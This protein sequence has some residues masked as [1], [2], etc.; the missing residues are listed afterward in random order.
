MPIKSTQ[1]KFTSGEIDPLLLGRSDLDR[2]YGAAE[3]IT[4]ARILPQGGIKRDDGLEYI[5]R[6]HR[7]V[8]RETSPTITTPNGGTGANANDDDTTTELITT[9]NISTTNPYVVVHY[10][11]GSQKDLAFI[12]VVGA[13]LT[14]ATNS[15][16]FFI[17]VSTD[18]ATWASLGDAIDMSSSDV[19]RRRR[20]RG[21]YRYVR[22]AR[23]GS[24]DLT[25][26]KVTLDEFSVWV[27]SST[28]SS[29]KQI[30]FEFS[31]TQ[32]Y[33]LVLTD[34]NIAV[35]RNKEHQI[36]VRAT[37]ITESI[38]SN[39][40]HT[41]SADTAILVEETI[42][43]QKLT[44]DGSD[45]KWIIGDVTFE[46]VPKYDFDPVVSTSPGGGTLTPSATSGIITLT[47][48]AG[49]PFS[50][51]SVGQYLT[52]G[53]GRAR[54]I[55]YTST[56]VVQA[57]TEIPF[58]NTTA[59]AN[60]SWDYLTGWEDAWSS[61]RGYPKTVTFH[62]GRLFFGGST[63]RPQTVWGSKVGVFFDFDLGSLDDS[64]GLDATLNTDQINE[65]VNLK[66]TNGNLLVF[67]SGAEFVIPQSSS[68]TITPA[69]FSFVPV[70][71][72]GSEPGFNIGVI[73]GSNIFIQRGG[74]S[75]LRFAY[76]TL[77]Q[78]SDSENLSLLSSHLI[79]SPLDFT[80]RKST[81][82]EETNLILFINGSG[83]LV[84][85]TVL[86]TQGVIGF[87]KRET[88]EASGSFVNVAVD[89][90][91]IYTVV[92]RTVN[93]VTNKYIEVM[94]DD[95]LL[96][97]S[98]IITTGLPT[99]TFSGLDHLEGETVKVIADGSIL[100][101]RVVSSG[102]ITIERDA[103][104]SIEIGL[105]MSPIIKTLPIEVA[106]LGSR[107]GV[108]KRI[109]EVVLRLYN[110]GDFTVNNDKVSFRTFGE[111]GAGSPLDAAPPTFTGDKKIKG[112]LGWNERNQITI[113]QSEPTDLQIL[114]ITMNV[115]V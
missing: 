80:V 102:S 55:Q 9:T 18:N 14:S 87:T 53:G 108:R 42:P 30:P 15:T 92:Q 19:T 67:T 20:A 32:S 114:S 100:T 49:T 66:S 54:I 41:Q 106:Q 37:Y 101:D 71:Q 34:R 105:N 96:D 8:T 43:P 3:T 21:T 5:D 85:G 45:D 48:S 27:E 56:T 62:S 2:Y 97:S 72:F 60:G 23:I 98:K 70:S 109:S 89:V 22:F 50:S 38:I 11:L 65:I 57:V 75:I 24:T 59:I 76:D 13:K 99:N 6:L 94:N 90:S 52:G 33:I 69:T 68:T 61:S 82:T 86:F 74:K 4:N 44:R 79:S 35:Y 40:K 77:Q 83:Q 25:T 84:M 47:A 39:I 112:L 46:N 110:T 115:N 26:D 1:F 28:V 36:D 113:S 63:E 58:F 12:D 103:E 88:T 31:V 107:I 51:A 81:S 111:A 73:S 16:E 7:Q 10:D 93:S 95:A 78:L 64:D 91:T 29:S 17:Q 104:T